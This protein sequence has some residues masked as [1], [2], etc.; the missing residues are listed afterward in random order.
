MACA[1]RVV[2]CNGEILRYWQIMNIGSLGPEYSAGGEGSQCL[3]L[4][5]PRIRASANKSIKE[6]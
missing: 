6:S 1:D 4:L 2:I 3:P 5:A